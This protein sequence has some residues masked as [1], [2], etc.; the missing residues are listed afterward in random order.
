M[1][2]TYDATHKKSS[3]PNQNFFFECKLQDFPRLL[4]FWP[5]W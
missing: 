3:P 1:S 5:G 4:S 2:S